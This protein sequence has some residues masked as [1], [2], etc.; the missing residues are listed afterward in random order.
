[1]PS[2]ITKQTTKQVQKSE[3]KQEV[4][5]EA[6]QPEVKVEPKQEVTVEAKQPEVKTESSSTV[7]D[8]VQPVAVETTKPKK[9]IGGVKSARGVKKNTK[10][11]TKKSVKKTI[12]ATKK[13]AKKKVDDKTTKKAKTKKAVT[14]KEPSEKKA[15]KEKTEDTED[16]KDKEPIKLSTEKRKRY[17]KL[18]LLDEN[19]NVP[20]DENGKVQVEQIGRFS[21]KKP[22][23]AASKACKTVIKRM[24]EENKERIK[25]GET[26]LPIYDVE[27]KFALKECTRWNVKK[28]KKSESGNGNEEKI[29]YYIGILSL[30]DKPVSVDHVQGEVDESELKKGQLVKEVVVDYKIKALNDIATEKDVE[31]YFTNVPCTKKIKTKDGKEETVP[32]TKEQIIKKIHVVEKTFDTVKNKDGKITKVPKYTFTGEIKYV[33]INKIEYKCT[34]KIIKKP[35]EEKP[36]KTD[37]VDETEETT[38]EVEEPKKEKKVKKVKAKKEVKAEKESKK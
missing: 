24:E 15:K 27:I 35:V 19:G 17:F 31:Y 14:K 10:K 32:T 34:K 7:T 23:Q 12:K 5:V 9:K 25:K 29:N 2:K 30:L 28:Y 21:G 13:V 6:K 1:M 8:V 38:P 4:T 11:T 16:T 20:L 18:L 3:P 36:K 33:I 26:P 37:E 22:K